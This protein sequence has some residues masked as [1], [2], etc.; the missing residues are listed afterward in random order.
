MGQTA[1]DIRDNIVRIADENGNCVGTGFFIHKEYCVTCHH[2]I[3][4]LNEIYVE[5]ESFNIETGDQSKRRYQA[6][7][8]EEL[9]D[10]RKDVAFL[11]V[12]GADVKVLEYWRETYGNIPVAVR[13]FPFQDLYNFPLG[14]EERGTLTDIIQPFRW[15][16]EKIELEGKMKKWNTK[17]EV[18]IPVY[19]FNGKFFEGFSGAPVCYQH[20]WKIVG[21]F[22]ARDDNQ[23]FMIPMNMVVELFIRQNTDKIAVEVENVVKRNTTEPLGMNERSIWKRNP[24]RT[25]DVLQGA[26]ILWVDDHPE[27]NIAECKILDDLAISVTIARSTDEAISILLK[28][29][30]SGQQYDVIISDMGRGINPNEGVRFLKKIRK[31]HK[32]DVPVIFYAGKYDPGRG[33]PPYAFGMTNRPD[34]LLHYIMDAL[35]R[36]RS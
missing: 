15:K 31:E 36:Q 22:E 12:Q 10:M 5:K 19:T 18:N 7:W 14:R 32:I 27:N 23:G 16:E 1:E 26:H 35:E 17:P 13:G 3:C 9:S 2:N 20:D 25:A 28:K 6:E 29:N 4:R 30:E 34:H 8:V 21:I 33:I 11:K 24:Q